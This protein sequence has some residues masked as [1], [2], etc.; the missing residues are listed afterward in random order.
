MHADHL[1][2]YEGAAVPRNWKDGQLSLEGNIGEQVDSV[3]GNL[4]DQEKI[5]GEGQAVSAWIPT[6]E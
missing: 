5:V 4:D 6:E 3:H 1:K 2:L